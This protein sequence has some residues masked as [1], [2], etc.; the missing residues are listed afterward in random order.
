MRF[1]LLPAAFLLLAGLLATCAAGGT[2]TRCLTRVGQ[3]DLPGVSGRIDHLDLD[4]K[5]S[6]LFVAALG[7]GTVEVVDLAKKK[8]IAS[9]PGFREPQGVV[10]LPSL[11]R[12]LVAEGEGARADVLD[13]KSLKTVATI[14]LRDDPDNTRLDP[15]TGRVYVGEGSGAEGAIAVIDVEKAK[16]VKEI[17]LDGHPESFK[18]ESKG[19]RIFVNVPEQRAVEVVDEKKGKVTGKLKLRDAAWNF[20]MALDEARHRLYVGCR[21]PAVVLVFDTKTGKVV[22][23]LAAPGDADD[24]FLDAKRSRVYVSGGEG[25]VRVWSVSK[26]GSYSLLARIPTAPGARTSLFAPATDRLYVACPRRGDKPAR[27][28]VY[29]PH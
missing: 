26:K 3:I 29:A 23:R 10:W 12:L 20:P 22:T 24:I 8:R 19:N 5:G 28:L 27:I 15:A 7:N 1:P 21:S 13:G 4:V 9:L 25:Q 11:K 17:P 18:L 16:K 6:R 14:K 2:K